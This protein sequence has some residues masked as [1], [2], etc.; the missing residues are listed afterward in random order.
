VPQFK[1]TRINMAFLTGLVAVTVLLVAALDQVFL[2]LATFG[3]ADIFFVIKLSD[4]EKIKISLQLTLSLLSIA[5]LLYSSFLIRRKLTRRAAHYATIGVVSTFVNLALPNFCGISM[6]SEFLVG[7]LIAI[8]LGVIVTAVGFST[9]PI[10]IAKAEV[11]SIEAAT[12]AIFSA[13][14]AVLTAGVGAFIPSPTGGYT[15]IGDTA[16]FVAALLFGT[17]VGALSG[18]VGSVVADLVVGYP[19]WFVSIPAHGLEG[20]ISGLGK[21]RHTIV[22]I[23]FCI[24]GGFMMA[25]IYFGVNLF[26][27]GYPLAIISYARDFFGQALISLTLGIIFTKAI[28]RAL[29]HLKGK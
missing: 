17:R 7:N 5:F 28:R 25:S 16:I 18:A 29:P 22:Q 9:P 13:L 19:R 23:I 21:G 4:E 11:K 26:I 15:H 1:L 24:V 10:Q 27:K 2:M 12:V 6:S 14:T 20:A 8:V 3:I